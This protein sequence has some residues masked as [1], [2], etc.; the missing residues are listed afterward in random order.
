MD[1][2]RGRDRPAL[3]VYC[4]GIARF[5]I[6]GLHLYVWRGYKWMC[7]QMMDD[8]GNVLHP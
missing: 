2:D 6:R 4:V 5:L 3:N 7:Q 1:A 8:Q